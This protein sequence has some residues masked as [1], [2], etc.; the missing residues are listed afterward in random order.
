MD[1]YE[2]EKEMSKKKRKFYPDNFIL[3]LFN[4]FFLLYILA[5]N[6]GVPGIWQ[7]V[8]FYL[9]MVGITAG[10]EL[11]KLGI[12]IETYP[13][14][15]RGESFVIR[16]LLFLLAIVIALSFFGVIAFSGGAVSYPLPPFPVQLLATGSALSWLIVVNIA[17]PSEE[18][19][20][21]GL[22]F[23][24]SDEIIISLSKRK[25]ITYLIIIISIIISSVLNALSFAMFHKYYTF[26][27]YVGAFAF[28]LLACLVTYW[29]KSTGMATIM[30]MTLNA[31]NFMQFLGI[32][33]FW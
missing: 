25:K 19:C 8:L 14:I 17:P 15:K 24:S 31:F 29:R 5:T 22:F 6:I 20:W 12:G 18:T 33:R 3:V 10:G 13:I 32:I 4:A 2:G 26:S 30:H 16:I 27:A 7:G 28:G 11:L 1:S 23:P 9:I 21:R